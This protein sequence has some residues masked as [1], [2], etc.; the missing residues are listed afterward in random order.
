M[1]IMKP[2][3]L[4]IGNHNMVAELRQRQCIKPKDFVAKIQ[5][6]RNRHKPYKLL[7]I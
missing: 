7:K 1:Q 5:I 4:S 2:G 6:K 3:K